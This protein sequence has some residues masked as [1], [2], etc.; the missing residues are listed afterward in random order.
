MMRWIV[1]LVLM[2]VIAGCG[3][4]VEVADVAVPTPTN[5]PW[6]RLYYSGSGVERYLAL[7]VIA[8]GESAVPRAELFMQSI[9]EK[10]YILTERQLW[11]PIY[12]R[13]A[14]FAAPQSYAVARL[15]VYRQWDDGGDW[16][17]Y[18]RAEERI[19]AASAPAQTEGTLG[20]SMYVDTVDQFRVRAEVSLL[21]YLSNG[22]T[23]TII[24]TREFT[25]DVL[26]H[27][28]DQEPDVDAL[29]P[30]V[31]GAD[32]DYL[33]LDWR[34]WQG[35]PCSLA[36][37]AQGTGAHAPLDAACQAFE[38]GDYTALF[39]ALDGVEF[40]DIALGA[41]VYAVAGLLLMALNQPETAAQA[42]TAAE[43]F[44][45]ASDDVV[46]LAANAHNLGVAQVALDDIDG[47]Y[48]TFQCVT[49]LRNQF[50]DEAG[51][52]LLQAN[53]AYLNRDGGSVDEAANFFRDN[54]L[55]QSTTLDTWLFRIE[56]GIED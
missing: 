51:N 15:N 13:A 46:S 4:R 50:W 48:A 41:D 47:A 38:S 10:T 29:W 45:A 34:A 14:W 32:E 56:N 16:E 26:S 35:G 40:E 42:F 43:Q 49:E 21:A 31:D 52:R 53:V 44:A 5:R 8:F 28:G 9:P 22:E 36:F 23:A 30:A 37:R 55:P 39:D 54:G 25:I 20:I 18:D 24:D 33:L 11:L 3:V 6:W 1:W 2:L 7:P 17:L 27:P 19:T 12:Y